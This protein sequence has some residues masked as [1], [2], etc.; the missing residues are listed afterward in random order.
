MDEKLRKYL[1]VVRA[2]SFTVAARQLRVSQPALTMAVRDLERELG[3]ELLVRRGRSFDVSPAGRLVFD[4][5]QARF[6]DWSGLQAQ[7]ADIS[8]DGAPLSIGM[9]DSLA[10]LA[11]ADD[12]VRS[13]LLQSVQNRIVVDNSRRLMDMVSQGAIDGA[14]VVAQTDYPVAISHE[15]LG[16]ES[17]SIVVAP[18]LLDGRHS[19]GRL[20]YISYDQTSSTARWID[21]A[22]EHTG[23]IGDSVFYSTSPQI[24]LE[25]CRRAAGMTVLPDRMVAPAVARNELAYHPL[26]QELA[27]R[28]PVV[29]VRRHGAYQAQ[30]VKTVLEQMSA[31]L[32]VMASRRDLR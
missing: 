15:Q 22:L 6:Q 12:D 11:F 7:L 4:Y 32:S 25:L 3:V 18:A 30:S 21:G 17:M 28:R 8:G 19:R 26:N 23:L 10:E 9:I 20:P 2:G 31:L 5:A 14:V 16:S 27:I 24:M 1:Y 29:S 13:Q